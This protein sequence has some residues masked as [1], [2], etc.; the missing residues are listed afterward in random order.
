MHR[1]PRSEKS[2][3]EHASV[4]L[5]E[6]AYRLHS[7]DYQP[8][9]ESWLWVKTVISW[10]S[11]NE[12]TAFKDL[13]VAITGV[14]VIKTYHWCDCDGFSLSSR[15]MCN[16]CF[17]FVFTFLPRN[18]TTEILTDFWHRLSCFSSKIWKKRNFLHHLPLHHR[19]LSSLDSKLLHLLLG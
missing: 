10:R 2:D 1:Y 13:E 16:F 19:A 18:R 9:Q 5:K 6:N 4:R 7:Q 15:I 17:C 8:G 12:L 3:T 11:S 14:L